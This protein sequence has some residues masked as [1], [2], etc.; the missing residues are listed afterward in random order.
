MDIIK[1]KRTG[2][3]GVFWGAIAFG[4]TYSLGVLSP[5]QAIQLNAYCYDNNG[6]LIPYCYLTLETSYYPYTNGHFHESYAH[7]YS[8]VSPS[9]MQ[10]GADGTAPVT[11][12]PIGQSEA[13]TV[14]DV[15]SGNC[16]KYQYYVG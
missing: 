3:C 14:C 11:L 16:V 6:N 13:I 8:S 2:L 4:Q 1:L 10:A 9:Y 7:P 5:S 15:Q 12:T